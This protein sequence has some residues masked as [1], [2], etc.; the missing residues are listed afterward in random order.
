MDPVVARMAIGEMV[1][2]HER[3]GRSRQA[4]SEVR[5][6][7]CSAKAPTTGRETGARRQRC[8]ATV[9]AG[10]APA[11][12]GRAPYAIRAPHPAVARIFTPA[13]IMERRPTPRLI[14]VP[15]PTAVGPGPVAGVAVRTPGR[16]GHRGGR[17]PAPA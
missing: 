4:E 7:G 13:A 6:D 10:L 2:P 8:P 1:K 5:P 14:R 15:I 3:E 16:A 12:P 17:P 11:N 9:A